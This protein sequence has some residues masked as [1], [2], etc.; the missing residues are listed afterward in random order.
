VEL[1]AGLLASSVTAAVSRLVWVEE[2]LRAL[3]HPVIRA[4][5]LL[6]SVPGNKS[7]LDCHATSGVWLTYYLIADIWGQVHVTDV[8]P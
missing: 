8:L 5:R 2:T 4:P 7:G 6:L 3:L 1:G